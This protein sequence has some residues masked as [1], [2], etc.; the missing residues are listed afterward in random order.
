LIRDVKLL[1]ILEQPVLMDFTASSP[2]RATW[3]SS[4]RAEM[5][6]VTIPWEFS[7]TSPRTDAAVY[8]RLDVCMLV[9]IL[10]NVAL[11]R[12]IALESDTRHLSQVRLAPTESRR[13]LAATV[14]SH[15]CN[16]VCERIRAFWSNPCVSHKRSSAAYRSR[17]RNRGLPRRSSASSSP[18]SSR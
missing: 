18:C 17:L 9:S 3:R 5:T 12:D 6:Q 10:Y 4:H 14:L 13:H 16:A 15:Y 11:R 2:S 1:H 8:A 7:V